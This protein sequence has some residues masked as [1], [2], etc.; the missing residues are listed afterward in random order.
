IYRVASGQG[1]SLSLQL[2]KESQM[3]N[4]RNVR[5]TMIMAVV[6]LIAIVA[7]AAGPTGPVGPVGDISHGKTVV[8]LDGPVA[9]TG[10]AGSSQCFHWK[11]GDTNQS[12]TTWTS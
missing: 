12:G 4:V 8:A 10:P 1:F 7:S 9:P 11:M 2:L 6:A 5:L 3:P